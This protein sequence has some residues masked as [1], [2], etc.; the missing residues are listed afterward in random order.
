MTIIEK[1]RKLKR[2]YPDHILLIRIGDF[3]E[4]F[5]EDAGIVSGVC[6]IVLSYRPL[7]RLE[8]VPMAGCPYWRTEE[9]IATLLGAGHKVALAEEVNGDRVTVEEG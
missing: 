2:D 5:D 9:M 4:A 7:G 6:S 3:V 1:Y 8:Q